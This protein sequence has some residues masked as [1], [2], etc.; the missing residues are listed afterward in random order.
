MT[1]TIARCSWNSDAYLLF[2]TQEWYAQ[3]GCLSLGELLF[4][5]DTM[6]AC[7]ECSNDETAVGNSQTD[8]QNI[9]NIKASFMIVVFALP[10]IITTI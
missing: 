5:A 7:N 1:P 2:P 6:D 8:E 3:C 4:Y 9:W 10:Q